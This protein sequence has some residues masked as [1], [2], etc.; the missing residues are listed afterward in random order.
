MNKLTVTQQAEE[1]LRKG[2]L[3]LDKKDFGAL[4]LQNQ[5]V[6]LQN[7]QGK[8]LGTAYLSEEGRAELGFFSNSLW[9]G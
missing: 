4:S 1:K 5:C 6:Q 2:I 8:F 9:A 3:L 7:R